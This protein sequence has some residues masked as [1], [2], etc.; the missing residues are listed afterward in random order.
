MMPFYVVAVKA[1]EVSG[2]AVLI[3]QFQDASAEFSGQDAGA[4]RIEGHARDVIGARGL[5]ELQG[6]GSAR[7][8]I[9]PGNVT[10]PIY[11]SETLMAPLSEGVAAGEL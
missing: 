4:V 10:V 3:H 6:Q 5:H 1:D 2:K 11:P 9:F 7:G 8:S